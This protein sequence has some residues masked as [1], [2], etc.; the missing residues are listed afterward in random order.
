MA[1]QTVHCSTRL[2]AAMC[3]LFLCI[4]CFANLWQST[5]TQNTTLAFLLMISNSE[6]FNS[7]GA[8]VAAILAVERINADSSIL[9][10]YT[11]GLP[12][13]RDSKVHDNCN[14]LRLLS[15]SIVNIKPSLLFCFVSVF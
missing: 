9:H 15:T 6:R 5:T 3:R 4:L 14:H 12:Y 8:E 7:S 1:S 11:L 13:V 2:R 10:G